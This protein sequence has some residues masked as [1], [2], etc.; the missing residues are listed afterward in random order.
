M[1]KRPIEKAK[2]PTQAAHPET[3]RQRP[4]SG[5]PG[6]ESSKAPS[7][8]KDGRTAHDKDG[9]SEQKARWSGLDSPE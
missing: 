2:N 7:D 5:P 1:K 6:S 3:Q 4:R 8:A 9:N